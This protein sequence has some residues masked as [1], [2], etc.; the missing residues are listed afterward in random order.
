MA[1]VPHSLLVFQLQY[2]R[3]IKNVLSINEHIYITWKV[4]GKNTPTF[5]LIIY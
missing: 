1:I 5:T 3:H 2:A 4:S